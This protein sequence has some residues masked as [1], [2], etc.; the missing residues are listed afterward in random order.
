[1]DCNVVFTLNIS[2]IATINRRYAAGGRADAQACRDER[3]HEV[4]KRTAAHDVCIL[5][6][7]IVDE[8]AHHAYCVLEARPEP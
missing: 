8:D 3:V 1:M 6:I 2:L 4:S 7:V 5:P